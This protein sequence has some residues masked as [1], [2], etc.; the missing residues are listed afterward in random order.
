MINRDITSILN[1][2]TGLNTRPEIEGTQGSKF[3]LNGLGATAMAITAD[4]TDANGNPGSPTVS[5][6][7]GYTKIN[8]M[9][10]EA[11][12]Q[13]QI[14]KGVVPAEY[15]MA[16]GGQMSVITKSG[17]NDWHGSLF[18]RYE[19]SI[20][21]ARPQFLSKENNSVWNQF[22]GSFGGPIKRDKVFF[23]AAYEGYR[24]RGVV[25]TNVNVPTERFRN[26]LS[27]SLPFPETQLWL[28]YYPLPNQ[29]LN[30]PDALTAVWI[31]PAARSANDDH[32]DSK[33]DYLVGGGNLS[34]S[35]MAAHPDLSVPPDL[36][37]NPR[38][39]RSKWRR[40]SVNYVLG[41]GPWTFSTRAGYNVARLWRVQDWWYAN[42]PNKPETIHGMRNIKYI[43]YPGLTAVRG[44]SHVRS[45]TPTY[46][47][48]QHV[49]YLRGKHSF[50]F[51]G[52]L[53]LP[54]GG[55]PD[56]DAGSVSYQTLTDVMNNTPSAI[57]FDSGRPDHTWRFV[58][59]GF[60]AQD[61]WRVNRKFVL[62]MGL[63][64]DRFG[65]F[66]PQALH[67]KDPYGTIG[68]FNLEGFCGCSSFVWNGPLRPG[69]N[70]FHSDNLSL[71]PRLGL[72]Y[73]LDDKG[74]FVM[75][76]GF[77]INFQGYDVQTF[78]DRLG[79]SPRIPNA[80]SVSR[81]EAAQLGWKYPIYQEDMLIHYD[82][83]STISVGALVDPNFKPAYAMNYTLGF[84]KALTST[85]VLE[86]AYVGTRG[87]KFPMNRTYNQVDRLTGVRPNPNMGQ[88]V[89]IDN[90]QET[91]YHSWQSSLR[92]RFSHGVLFNLNYTWAKALSYTGGGTA[93][94]A[95]G[96]TSGTVEDFFD[97]KIERSL[98]VGDVAHSFST[99][100]L[101]Q[102]PTPFKSSVLA[103]H[104]LGGWQVAGIIRASTG[105]PLMVTQTGGRP[106]LVDIAG[107]INNQCCSFGNLQYLNRAAFVEQ[108]VVTASG[109]TPRRGYQS[110]SPLRT[111][112]YSNLDVSLG[113]SFS[114]EKARFELKAD[115][116][117]AL[118][119]TQYKNVATNLSSSNFGQVTA[120]NGARIIQVQL[121][122]AF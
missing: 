76:G 93:L 91:V 66:S 26:I 21:S 8:V 89:Y 85:M 98:S 108:R 2:G 114:L 115:I 19:G 1:V 56:T 37:T 113:K 54:S 118:N 100:V 23:F 84:Q 92:Q 101:Y 17:T 15:G 80:A 48:E 9:S 10:S 34:L 33:L 102:L 72:A 117:N 20:L 73:T 95:G 18:H 79:R 67:P 116:Q 86:T 24:Q 120:T 82:S 78:E 77:G 69:D 88:G 40:A 35:M 74:D 61:D 45:R 43:N 60:F 64:Y 13:T 119:Q 7:Y 30:V 31:G 65:K 83:L 94:V 111:P 32:V 105:E 121:R 58:N 96:D 11:V 12:G 5:G 122:L 16:M 106:D 29:P 3:R 81:L 28:K 103:R 63:R 71:A 112:G 104:V 22:G 38:V 6:Y 107:A 41:K 62:N 90:S 27:T 57:S 49:G 59:F 14:V 110:S 87:V 42:D 109:R 68:F 36:P 50:K 52:M 44:E 47:A 53:Y 99:D 25:A 97:I 46:T 75:R 4:G 55:N 39:F 51:G 70:P